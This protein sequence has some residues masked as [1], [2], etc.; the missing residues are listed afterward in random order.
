[1]S[2]PESVLAQLRATVRHDGVFWRRFAYLGCVYGPEWFKRSSPPVFGAIIFA[3]VSRNR[4]IAIENMR[5][6]LGGQSSLSARL[7]ALEM[8]ADFSRCFS[9]T[10]ECYGPRPVDL[11]IDLP[12]TDPLAAA[13]EE[14][15]GAVVVTG[16]FG[17]W[18]IAAKTLSEYGRPINTVMVREVNSSTHEFVREARERAGVRI[19]YSDTSAFSSFGMLR[20]L[21][22]NEIVAMQL[23]RGAVN[24]A[25]RMIP[26]FDSPAPF[27]VGPFALARVA[28]APLIPVFIPRLGRH[29]YAVRVSGAFRVEREAGPAALAAV[30]EQVVGEL[31]KI[32]REF[33]TQ[34]FQFAELWPAG[35]TV[36]RPVD[37]TGQTEPPLETGTGA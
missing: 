11:R 33:P 37:A 20:A 13:L 14:G 23:D 31:E 15:R 19:I 12:D 28:R 8:F 21:R 2:R 22:R 16:H 27:P 36:D 35:Q 30:M 6:V 9:E 24:E 25:T 34:W 3:L 26:F 4:R 29:H 32:V 18:D 17:N 5:H 10:M 1:M 7:A